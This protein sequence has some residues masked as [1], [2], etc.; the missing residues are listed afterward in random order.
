MQAPVINTHYLT[1]WCWQMHSCFIVIRL[2]FIFVL[3]T[4]QSYKTGASEEYIITGNDALIKCNIPSFMSDFV[5][6]TSWVS[7]EGEQIYAGNNFG[8]HIS[9]F[10]ELSGYHLFT[11]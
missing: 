3:V 5:R 8:N 4:Q 2:S 7:S 10:Y 1:L 11:F 6:V 9:I